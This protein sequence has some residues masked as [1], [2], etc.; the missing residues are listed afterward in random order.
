MQEHLFTSESVTEGHP[1]KVCDRISDAILDDILAH[2]PLARVACETCTNTG[3]VLVI[4]EITT[5]HYANVQEI[6]RNTIR[7]IGYTES[8]GLSAEQCAVLVSLDE[9]SADIA[10]GVNASQE[11][12][13]GSSDPFD[14][15][16]AGDQ[17]MMFGYASTESEDFQR[18]SFMPMPIQLAHALSRR[19][20]ELRHANPGLGLRPDGKTQVSA[21]YRGS[22]FLGIQT[23][24]VSSQHEPDLPGGKLHSIVREDVIDEVVPGR[25]RLPEM[26]LHVNPTGKF[27][28][29]GPQGDSG[30][31]G[32][33]IIVDTYGG[34][35]R[36][37][38]GAFS[39]KDPTKVDRSASYY[40]RYAA[41]N[42]VA[43]GVADRLE[44]QVS[45]AIGLSH[46]TSLT[47][48]CFGTQQVPLDRIQALLDSR[49]IFDFRPLAI[50]DRLQLRQTRY[51]QVSA[52]GHFGRTDLDL[53]WERLDQVDALS[54]ALGTT[55]VSA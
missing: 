55:A 41:K 26:K 27:V 5:S 51:E 18:G 20:A 22:E 8:S 23:L 42:L 19:L 13:D 39:G 50:I 35:A 3:L 7:R 36:H 52:Y 33:K 25:L 48:E 1:D 15:V 30:L 31:T 14:A 37:G 32:R 34:T 6:V 17:G 21:R 49:D 46:P 4:G 45:Y 2:D 11:A 9:Q 53:P 29:G 38:G 47:V 24:V 28:I 12:R 10:Q 44:L 16:G 43:A 40:A 54:Q